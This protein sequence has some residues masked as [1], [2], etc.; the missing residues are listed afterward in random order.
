MFKFVLILVIG[1]VLEA[2]G[3]VLLSRGLKEL[4]GLDPVTVATVARLVK[5]AVMHPKILAGVAFE[6]G[7]FAILL[8]LLAR[9]EV[10]VVWPLTSLGFV[11]T[12]LAAR[13]YLH[14]T[15]SGLR[16]TGV[17]LIVL[18]AAL[19]SLGQGRDKQ[20]ISMPPT[21]GIASGG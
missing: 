11:I 13:I 18:G 21:A 14:E 2:I 4:G 16:W 12:T 7:F 1:L 17:I 19:V 20:G 3:V 10:S 6:A 8:F 5:S 9:A 15:I